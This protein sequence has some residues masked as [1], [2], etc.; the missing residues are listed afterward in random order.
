MLE[1]C[2]D[3]TVHFFESDCKHLHVYGRR[4]CRKCRK[5]STEGKINSKYTLKNFK[6]LKTFIFTFI[7]YFES[8]FDRCVFFSDPVIS[9]GVMDTG[10]V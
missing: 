9:Y 8:N 4:Q 5:Q 7:W 6:I 3:R 10:T 2:A 1:T